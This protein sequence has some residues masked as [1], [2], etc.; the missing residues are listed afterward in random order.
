M[1]YANDIGRAHLLDLPIFAN[2]CQFF[3][4]FYQLLLNSWPILCLFFAQLPA[5][6]GNLTP[7]VIYVCWRNAFRPPF[8]GVAQ[9]ENAKMEPVDS[10]TDTLRSILVL[11]CFFSLVALVA[12]LH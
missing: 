10:V 4:N 6:C 7:T 9:S 5:H 2:F 8:L 3:A 1:S 11:F 12:S